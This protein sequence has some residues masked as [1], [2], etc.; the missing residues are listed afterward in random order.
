MKRVLAFVLSAVMVFI[1]ACPVFAETNT[2]ELEKIILSVKSRIGDTESYKDFTSRQSTQTDGSTVYHLQWVNREDDYKSISVTVTESGIITSYYVPASGR[3]QAV[4]AIGNMDREPALAKAKE[5]PQKLNPSIQEEIE[6]VDQTQSSSLYENG[7]TFQLKRIKNGVEVYE[8]SGFI[9]VDSTAETI[10]GY[11]LTYTENAV[12]DPVQAISVSEAQSAFTEK[13]GLSLKYLSDYKDHA[14]QIYPAY[15][16]EGGDTKVSAADGAL[17]TL[18]KY[19]YV[20]STPNFDLNNKQEATGSASDSAANVELSETELSELSKIANLLSKDQGL[21]IIRNNTHIRMDENYVLSNYTVQRDYYDQEEYYA[22]YYFVDQ[23][24]EPYP[25]VSVTINAVTG[26]I[27]NYF[28]NQYEKDTEN[29]AISEEEAQQIAEAA[30]ADFA[31]EKKSEYRLNEENSNGYFGYTRYVN[32]IAYEADS[33]NVHVDLKT[34]EI[35]GYSIGYTD[36]EFPSIDGILTEAQACE[37]LFEQ[38]SYEAVYAKNVNEDGKTEFKLVYDFPDA[39]YVTL[40]P[41]TGQRI[42]YNNDPM[43]EPF[44]GYS[45]VAGHYAETII[46]KLAEYGIRVQGGYFTPDEKITQGDFLKLLDCVF[47]THSPIYLKAG[48]TYDYSRLCRNGIISE[49]EINENAPVTRLDAAKFIIRAMGAEEYAKLENIYASP[50]TD[51]TTDAGYVCI[52]YGMGVI[53]G[54]GSGCYNPSQSITYADAAVMIYNYLT[55]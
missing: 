22:T 46:N 17:I 55:R 11:S 10:T 54:D 20:A 14:L 32:G 41:F 44:T 13:L 31:G 49:E 15:V 29:A 50:F 30:A 23:S 5:L 48:T 45:D 52:L 26:E 2:E 47:W 33:I 18:V 39:S 28:T 6:V 25:Y 19:K 38:V 24:T 40:N 34:G 43:Q 36:A 35:S 53:I 51:V 3:Y 7:F 16:Y 1:M 9:S 42:D 21:E 37:K 4:P 27:I 12:F 8:N